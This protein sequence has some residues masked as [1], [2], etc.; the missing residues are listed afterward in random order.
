MTSTPLVKRSDLF[1]PALVL[2]TLL[3]G[4]RRSNGNEL[5]PPLGAVNETSA[6]AG[7]VESAEGHV[8]PGLFAAG[9]LVGGLFYHNYPG[10]AGLVSGAVLGKL[11]GDGAGAYV[12]GKN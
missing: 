6:T 7:E 11:A 10:G 1:A 3:T 5:V 4:W 9:E 12:K 2:V 8:I